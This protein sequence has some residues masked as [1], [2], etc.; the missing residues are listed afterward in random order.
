MPEVDSYI[1]M[2]FREIC[3]LQIALVPGCCGIIAYFWKQFKS[4]RRM[5]RGEGNCSLIAL[6][7]ILRG[8]VRQRPQYFTGQMSRHYLEELLPCPLA[9]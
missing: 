6:G 2:L 9:Q 7:C 5:K 1:T 3:Y 4:L 8:L